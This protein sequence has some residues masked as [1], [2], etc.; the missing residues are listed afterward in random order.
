MNVRIH[1][2]WKKLLKNEFEKEYFLNLADFVKN[3]Y[4]SNII[5]PPGPLIFNAFN[6]TPLDLVKVVILG[7]DPYHGQGQAHGLAFSVQDGVPLP[8]SLKNIFKELKS[9]LGIE[10][11]SSGNLTRWAEQGVFLLNSVLTVRKATP[12]SHAKK[13]WET[14]TDSVIKVLSENK[15][16][17]VFLLWGNYA[18]S[19][20]SLIDKNKHLILKA[21]HPSPFSADRGFFGCKHFSKT[22]VY[23][24]KNNISTINW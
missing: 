2:S 18:I 14:F 10:L 7:Q 12:G 23:L 20:E 22:N 8:P 21:P 5:Y 3:E 11:P 16:H 17:L 15:E 4:T 6:Q 13:G 1:P 9:D 24:N 19:K